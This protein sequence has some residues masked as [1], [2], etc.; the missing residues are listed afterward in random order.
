MGD[1]IRPR[2][3]H[4]DQSVIQRE[5][6]AHDFNS[7]RQPIILFRTYLH[8][9]GNEQIQL[10]S[11]GQKYLNHHNIIVFATIGILVSGQ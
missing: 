3:E 7:K 2:S 10:A 8:Y 6:E 9:P 4:G 11:K 1:D 5:T